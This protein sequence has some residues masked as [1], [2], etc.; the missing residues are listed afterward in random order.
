MKSL[1]EKHPKQQLAEIMGRLYTYS[2]TTTSGG[3]LSVR[4]R[5]G[6]IWITPGGVDKANLSADD[7]IR[8]TKDGHPEGNHSPSI[9]TAFHK[10]I[11]NVREDAGGVIHAHAPASSAFCIN[12]NA[13][14]LKVIPQIYLECG[15]AVTSGYAAPGSSL[16]SE[17][18]SVKVKE[19]YN[20]V[21]LDNHGLVTMGK[22]LLHALQRFEA[23]DVCARSILN[24]KCIGEPSQAGPGSLKLLAEQMSRSYESFDSRNE[25]AEMRKELS[26]ISRR[27]YTRRLMTSSLG[28]ISIRVGRDEFLIT[29]FG[30]DRYALDPSDI[31]LVK[32]DKTEAD[33]QPDLWTGLHAAIYREHP[34]FNSIM[35]AVPPSAMAFAVTGKPF[36]TRTLTEGYVLLRDIHRIGLA[37]TLSKP[38]ESAK[39]L[40][41]NAPVQLVSHGG[42]I[43]A[44]TTMLEVLDRIEVAEV[45]MRSALWSERL[46]GTQSLN[47]QEIHEIKDFFGL[48]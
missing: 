43:A 16:L 41:E 4:G 10:E 21:L 37:D 47:D 34:N 9:E 7:M 8:I 27:A 14:D 22:D 19:G 13:P 12:R 48:G 20:A 33:K 44:G 2:L 31:V 38:V 42:I 45:S 28:S 30:K 5:D 40:H 36:N 11:Y 25:Y 26:K 15:D 32:G 6:I 46:G 35:T 29:P 39:E 17:K 3:N 18:L 1:I 23:L 24:A